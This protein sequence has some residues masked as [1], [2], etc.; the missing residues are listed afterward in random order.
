MAGGSLF[1][2]M[3][4][5][6]GQRTAEH[7]KEAADEREKQ[8]ARDQGIFQHLASADDPEI[9]AMALSGLASLS[10]TDYEPKKGLA[11]LLGQRGPANPHALNIVKLL[12]TGGF[13]GMPKTEPDEAGEVVRPQAPPAQAT[14]GSAGMAPSP[15]APGGGIKL[16]GATIPAGPPVTLGPPPE[17]AEEGYVARVPPPPDPNAPPVPGKAPRRVFL[18]P[19]ERVRRGKVAAAEGDVEGE[20]AGLMAAGFTDLEARELIKQGYQRRAAGGALGA[21]SIAGELPDG[22]PAFAIFDRVTKQYLDAD[23]GAPIKDFRPRTTTASTSMGAAKES[24]ARKLF[25]KP[26][27]QLSQAQ[28]QQA[29]QESL[30]YAGQ[31]AGA[32]TTARGDANA[33]IPLSTAQRATFETGLQDDWRKAHGPAQIT[34]VAAAKMDEALAQFAVSPGAAAETVRVNFEKILDPNSVVREAE[35]NRQGE[36]LS[37]FNRMDGLWQKYIQGGGNVP[38]PVL[39]EFVSLAK[40]LAAVEENYTANERARITATAREYQIDPARILGSVQGV[41]GVGAP[42]PSVTPAAGPGAPPPAAPMAAT[43]PPGAPAKG[44]FVG[45]V[46]TGERIQVAGKWYGQGPNGAPVELLEQGGQW[47]T[48]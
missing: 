13:E 45:N 6:W 18:T 12:R 7:R 35:Y 19:D 38:L 41:G 39:Q 28:A 46:Y 36:G 5:G 27:A 26:Y 14:P 29:D 47:Y 44:S 23:T 42:P 24:A 33:R 17:P 2:G 9:A 48:R 30:T 15:S 3:L 37:I 1:T 34:A 21:Q 25:G 20:H 10:S 43:P 40:R 22:T 8:I 32:T 31:Y 4:E 16:A 11:K